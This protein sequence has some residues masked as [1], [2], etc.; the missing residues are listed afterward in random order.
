[1]Q[2]YTKIAIALILGVV[3][4][5]AAN[6]LG[7]GWLTSALTAIEPAGSAWIRLITMVVVPL[8]VASLDEHAGVQI[9]AVAGGGVW[10]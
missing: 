7:L 2:L 8:V 5:L 9:E 10:V 6:I 4:G 1:M 3:A